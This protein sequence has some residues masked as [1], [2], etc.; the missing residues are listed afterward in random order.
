MAVGFAVNTLRRNYGFM[1]RSDAARLRH[2]LTHTRMQNPTQWA[3]VPSVHGACSTGSLTPGAL[4]SAYAGIIAQ[5]TA[6]L[7]KKQTR[8]L[9][10]IL[11]CWVDLQRHF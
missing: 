11:D 3:S 7:S 2:A 6:L 8:T 5:N 1:R 9:Q 4:I 10:R